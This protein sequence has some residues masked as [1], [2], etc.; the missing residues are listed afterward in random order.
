[1]CYVYLWCCQTVGSTFRPVGGP[2]QRAAWPH[3]CVTNVTNQNTI[4]LRRWIFFFENLS[5][6]F[7]VLI[8]WENTR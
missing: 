5:L 1:M 6:N 7:N 2:A 3:A 8:F 4:S